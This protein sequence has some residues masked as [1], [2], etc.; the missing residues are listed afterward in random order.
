MSLTALTFYDCRVEGCALFG[1][2]RQIRELVASSLPLHRPAAV[3]GACAEGLTRLAGT[4]EL[5]PRDVGVERLRG[6]IA[7]Q[8]AILDAGGKVHGSSFVAAQTALAGS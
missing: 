6:Y 1:V 8:V 4:V 7:S 5:E 3:C 2:P